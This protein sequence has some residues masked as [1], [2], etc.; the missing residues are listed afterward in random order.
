MK[1]KATNNFKIVIDNILMYHKI[2]LALAFAVGIIVTI[3]TNHNNRVAWERKMDA[4]TQQSLRNDSLFKESLLTINK[5]MVIKDLKDDARWNLQDEKD[6]IMMSKM[7]N[8]EVIEV[9]QRSVREYHK[10]L[11]ILSEYEK[12]T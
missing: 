2:Y 10:L 9:V 8:S 12:K 3:T 6:S 1:K 5:N 7:E 4:S 11:N